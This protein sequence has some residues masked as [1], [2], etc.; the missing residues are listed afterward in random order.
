MSLD[1]GFH[2]WNS[3]NLRPIGLSDSGLGVHSLE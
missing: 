3:G 1:K 2:E